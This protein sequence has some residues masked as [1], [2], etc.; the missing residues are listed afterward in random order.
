[1]AALKTGS[2]PKAERALARPRRGERSES[3]AHLQLVNSAFDSLRSPFWPAF[4][5]YFAALHF[6]CFCL[7]LA[8]SPT[9][10]NGLL[11]EL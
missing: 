7:A 10:F 1:I 8:A 9:F 2:Q 3:N 11:R 5:C 4:G 6:A